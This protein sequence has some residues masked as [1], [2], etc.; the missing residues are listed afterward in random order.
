METLIQVKEQLERRGFQAQVFETAAQAKEYILSAIQPGQTVG[1]GGSATLMSMEMDK[2]LVEKGITFYN[3][4][5]SPAPDEKRRRLMAACGADV[6]LTSVNALTV[7]GR[8][9]NIDGHGN[10]VAATL[11]G[12]GRVIFVVGKNKLAQNYESAIERIKTVTCP[13]NARR[14]GRKTPCATLGYCTDCRTPQRMCASTVV[15]EYCMSCH[16]ME[17]LLVNEELGY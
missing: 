15:T 12:P 9:I 16:P 8:L 3:H 2:A 14:L 1:A 13:A 5:D 17:V 6:Y 7:D 4:W 11:Y 10:R